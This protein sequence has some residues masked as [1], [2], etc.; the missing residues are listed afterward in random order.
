M[1]VTRAGR[2]RF[3]HGAF[4]G[5]QISQTRADQLPIDLE[6][7]GRLADQVWL[8]QIAVPSSAACDRVYCSPAWIRC[9]LSCGI[10]T[11]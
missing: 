1:T 11:A 8:G 4:A 9:G 7:L 5:H 10:A 2:H 6:D 3:T